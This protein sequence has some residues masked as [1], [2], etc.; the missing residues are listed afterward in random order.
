MPGIT[1]IQLVSEQAMP[2]LLAAMAIQPDRI[3]HLCTDTPK[4]RKGSDSLRRAYKAA[5]LHLEVTAERLSAMPA[6]REVRD[7]VA[8][9]LREDE[10]AV[11]NFTGGTKLMSIGAYAAALVCKRPS[12]YVDT[13]GNTFVDGGT[14]PGIDDLFPD[15]DT[16]IS[17]ID[18][19]LSVPHV[20]IANG[21]ERVD[22]GKNWKPFLPLATF[23]LE[24]DTIEA[25]VQQ[26]AT[27][28][29]KNQPFDFKKRQA[30]ILERYEQPLPDM[31]EAI[32]G[33]AIESGLFEHRDGGLFLS[34]GRKERIEAVEFDSGPKPFRDFRGMQEF[35]AAF[36]EAVMPLQFLQG[37]W[38]EVAVADHLSRR[39]DCRDIRWSVQVGSRGADNTD[40]E[41]DIL[42]IADSLNLL[43]VSCKRGGDKGKL[44]RYL[45]ETEASAKRVGGS[46]AK[47]VFAVCLRPKQRQWKQLT[48][49]AEEL[50][51]E[52]ITREDIL[53]G[54]AR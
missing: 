48:G 10:K 44:S 21:V 26:W 15:G 6:M 46:F 47:K 2:N 33:P 53:A 54:H 36:N 38:W 9:L 50:R 28:I 22:G 5:S 27:E 40:M 17:Q 19:R 31:L 12:F 7:V 52:L 18:R 41:E 23:L 29:C 42:G 14:A 13:S 49:R 39:D 45:E 20:A 34:A 11:L 24:N 3:V 16:S 25:Q 51:I 35:L 32:A 4:T 30:W 8:R 1:L 43:Y 37:T